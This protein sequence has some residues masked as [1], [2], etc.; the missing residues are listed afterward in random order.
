MSSL[1]TAP[2]R[3]P[4]YAKLEVRGQMPEGTIACPTL[5]LAVLSSERSRR[6]CLARNR[7]LHHLASETFTTPQH[8]R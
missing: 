8:L 1:R 7:L 3:E 5:E 6:G 2:K 4:T